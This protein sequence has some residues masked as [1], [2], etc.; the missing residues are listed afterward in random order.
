MVLMIANAMD[1]MILVDGFGR[2]EDKNFLTDEEREKFNKQPTKE[3][4]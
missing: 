2:H 1:V 4:Q 3:S